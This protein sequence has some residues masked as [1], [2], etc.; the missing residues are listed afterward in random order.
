MTNC[1]HCSK[2]LPPRKPG[3]PG[4]S[5]KYCNGACR[6]LASVERDP[7]RAARW[8]E[9]ASIRKLKPSAEC[10]ECGDQVKATGGRPEWGYFCSKPDCRRAR[11]RIRGRAFNARKKAETGESYY[12]RFRPANQARYRARLAAGEIEPARKRNPESFRKNDQ[13]RR[14]RK[15]GAVI[16]DFKPGEIYR[17]DRWICQLC[18]TPVDKTLQYPDP[19]S[20]SLDHRTPLSRNGAHSKNNCQLAHLTCNV[21]KGSS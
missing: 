3:A 16:E 19:R 13:I 10:S 5:K 1:L 17:R 7:E 12:K 9:S 6:A 15:A 2:E 18:Q 21:K 20:A 11:N 8:R 4:P 14:A